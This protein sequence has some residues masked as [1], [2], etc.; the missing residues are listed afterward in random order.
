MSNGNA[1][2]PKAL[3]SLEVARALSKLSLSLEDAKFPEVEREFKALESRLLAKAKS[4]HE[5]REIS[6]RVTEEVLVSASFLRVSEGDIERLLAKMGRLGYTNVERRVHIAFA[7]ARW[8]QG[9]R[10][11]RQ[12]AVRLLSE[13]E[14]RARRLGARGELRSRLE[15]AV[16]RAR[17]EFLEGEEGEDR[18]LNA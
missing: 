16:A 18:H 5:R 12:A 11:W 15:A 10:K 4:A 17:F 3:R 13:A 7:F 8:S 14:R 2:K 1:R 9:R 6:R